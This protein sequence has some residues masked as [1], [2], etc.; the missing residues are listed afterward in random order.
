MAKYRYQAVRA[1]QPSPEHRTTEDMFS[2]SRIVRQYELGPSQARSARLRRSTDAEPVDITN[3]ERHVWGEVSD[4][5]RLL[6]SPQFSVIEARVPAGAREEWHVHDSATQF[7]Y[8]LEGTAR[9]QAAER[10]V[11]LTARRAL[12]LFNAGEAGTRF[13]VI[14]T[15]NMRGDASEGPGD[16]ADARG[17]KLDTFAR[18]KSDAMP[19][20]R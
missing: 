7:F 18:Q 8:V 15:P 10:T 20:S 13:L 6:D 9:M 16:A 4:G 17:R 19:D 12:R 5:W 11:D 1:L 2:S 3:A 14:I